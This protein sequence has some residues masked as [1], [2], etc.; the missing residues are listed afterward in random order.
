MKAIGYVRVSTTRQAE[1]GVSLEAQQGKM[2]AWAVLTG[3]EFIAVEIDAGISGKRADNRPGLQRALDLACK[4]KA[5][6]VTYSLSRL[7]RSVKDTLA[8]AERL[9]RAGANLVSLSEQIDTTTAAGRM[10]FKMLSV[11][12]EFEREQIGERTKSSLSHMRSQGFKTGGAVPFGFDLV[13]DGRLVENTA[14]QE[15]LHLI[16]SLKSEG[17]SLREIAAQ[18]ERKGIKSKTG[19]TSWNV[20]TVATLARRAA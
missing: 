2:Q 17:Y 13:A 7:S 4:E 14:E 19:K 20:K 8:I 12:A 3:A 1:E 18:L 10:M 11:L 5:V 6:L 16:A 9:D 15:A